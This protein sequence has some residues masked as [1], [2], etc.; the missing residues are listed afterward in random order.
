MGTQSLLRQQILL[1]P[2]LQ[3]QPLPPLLIQLQPLYPPPQR[4][5]LLLLL[6]QPQSL[7]QSQTLLLQQSLP[8]L[9]PLLLPPLLPPL[10]PAVHPLLQHQHLAPRPVLL[11]LTQSL[12]LGRVILM[13][14][15]SLEE[16]CLH[17]VWRPLVWLG[18]SITG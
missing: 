4:L 3:T 10:L 6:L 5:P 13:A 16:S 17:S 9:Q 8:L 2:T 15:A 14:G 11:F 18:S 7:H 12:T 1:P